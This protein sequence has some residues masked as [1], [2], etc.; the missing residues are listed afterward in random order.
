[1]S[2][3]L[4]SIALLSALPWFC[5]DDWTEAMKVVHA[6]KTAVKGSVSQVG[7]S[8]TYTMEFLSGVGARK[9]AEWK[10]LTDRVD[11]EALR[12]RKGADHN[13]YSGWTAAD[14]RRAIKTTLAREKPEMAVIMYGTNDV[15]NGVALQDYDR[16]MTAIVD[17]CL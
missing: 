15:S 8:I 10:T 16:D 7:D 17:A 1:M 9:S 14:G 3:L 13:N 11:V 5:A 6:R 2:P 12:S 4:R